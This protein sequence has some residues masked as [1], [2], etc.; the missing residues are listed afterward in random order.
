MGGGEKKRIKTQRQ[1]LFLVARR[2]YEER[3]VEIT[4]RSRREEYPAFLITIASQ[5][6]FEKGSHKDYN[7]TAKIKKPQ[8]RFL[9]F[10]GEERIRTSGRD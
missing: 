3:V 10:C 1:N 8:K 2:A 9:F 6:L 5:L 4:S 7:L